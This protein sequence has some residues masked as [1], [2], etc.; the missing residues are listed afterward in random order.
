MKNKNS[1]ILTNRCELSKLTRDDID[2]AM[3]L[4]TNEQVRLYLGGIL[5]EEQ[6]LD[7][8][9][10]WVNN[11]NDLY[12]SVRLLD[13]D[14]F[15]GILSISTHHDNESKELSYQFLPDYWGNGFAYE[16]IKALLEYLGTLNYYN[17]LIAETQTNNEK[18]CKLLS[19]LG[20]ELVRVVFRF[21]EKQSIYRVIL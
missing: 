17:F 2:E 4:F 8:L 18:S 19:K 14:D 6:S 9:H 21:G 20:F 15:I 5:S 1:I 12:L 16:T 11:K 3:G 10:G 7:K 13:T